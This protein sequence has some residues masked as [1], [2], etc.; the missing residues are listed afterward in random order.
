MRF[1]SLPAMAAIG[2]ACSPVA[3][4]EDTDD[5]PAQIVGK[6]QVAVGQLK[7]LD[8]GKPTQTTQKQIVESL[9]ELIARLEKECAACSGRKRPN[10]SKPL[11]DSRI[12]S[13]PGGMGDLHAARKEGKD[14]GE[15]PAH[16][17][18]RILQSMTE[19]FPAHYQRILERYYK[20]LAQERPVGGAED[21]P[22]PSTK[23]QPSSNEPSD[24]N[25][26]GLPAAGNER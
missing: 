21:A 11:A 24:S 8:T 9:D 6:M 17:R 14:W 22:E 10:P 5:A 2:L 18:D 4:Q 15:L 19:G 1:L 12:G 16:E 3:A 23:E 26:S 20:R 25:P 13:G 7:K